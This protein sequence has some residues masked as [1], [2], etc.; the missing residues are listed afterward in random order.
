MT[1]YLPKHVFTLAAG[2]AAAFALS[3]RASA[4]EATPSPSPSPAAT[5]AQAP[6]QPSE[7][8]LL[9]M[10]YDGKTHV[11]LAPYIWG[12]NVGGSFQY[13]IPT[14]P[15]RP[16]GIAQSGF[17][18]APSQYLP[19]LN[20]AAMVYA[21]VRKGDFDVW[22]D[23]IY[24]NASISSSTTGTITGP[25]GRQIPLSLDT[26]AH[27]STAV[28]EVA[29]GW[30]AARGHN[31]DLSLFTGIRSFPT[32]LTLDYNATVGKRGII[33]P[34]GTIDDSV[35]LSD[36]FV[37]LR[38]RVFFGDSHFFVPYYGDYG[39]SINTIPQQTWQAYGG[40]GYAFNHGQ[41][42]ILL[43]RALDYNSFA[44]NVHV[45]HLTMYGPLLGYTFQL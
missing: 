32:N 21:D 13:T 30:T 22:G 29:A 36:L 1:H 8:T 18:V 2:I 38:G 43:Y 24:V 3:D 28:W 12:A 37:G 26:N 40:G 35:Y 11:T 27:L 9:D 14:L 17:T 42:L 6:S 45:Q 23:V 5:M 15:G 39:T 41:T 44:P 20:T 33:A 25:R 7:P 34:S 31:A 19:K 4:Q 10:Q 16:R